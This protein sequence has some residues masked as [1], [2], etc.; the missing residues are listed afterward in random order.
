[1]AKVGGAVEAFPTG[2]PTITMTVSAAVTAGRLV[3]VTGN[4]TVGLAGAASLKVIGV[5][6][7]GSDFVG[8]PDKIAVKTGGAFRLRATGAI[9]AGDQVIAAANGTVSTL[10]AAGG[11]TAAD[12]NNARAVVGVA[13]EAI[14][15]GQDGLVLLQRVGG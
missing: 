2:A 14:A 8:T 3:E 13:L 6:L 15:G 10:A 12:I 5:A 9:A 11:A 4:R 7:E 1:M